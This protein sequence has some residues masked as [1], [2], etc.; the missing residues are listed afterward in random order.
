VSVE[1]LEP[2]AGVKPIVSDV[3]TI[4]LREATT[5]TEAPPPT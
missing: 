1:Q 5:G 2:A 3:I 4:D